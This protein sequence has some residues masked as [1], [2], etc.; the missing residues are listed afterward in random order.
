MS[1]DILSSVDSHLVL[2]ILQEDDTIHLMTILLKSGKRT[3]LECAEQS[4]KWLNKY[5]LFVRY[6]KQH[7]FNFLYVMINLH[8]TFRE[9]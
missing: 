4:Y 5:K 9:E 1:K 2:L 3:Q 8:N 6:I 7:R